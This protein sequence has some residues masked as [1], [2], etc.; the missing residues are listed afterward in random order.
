MELLE[1]KN[2][3][4]IDPGAP[5]PTI[6]ANDTELHITF[7]YPSPEENE[8]KERNPK[9]DLVSYSIRFINFY[10]MK[11]GGPNDE[12]LAGHPYYSIGLRAYS[13]YE[14]YESNWLSEL[15]RIEMSHP[16]Y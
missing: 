7:Y 16:Y 10:Q 9:M 4:E 13:F 12:S 2:L 5:S 15:K 8:L 1:I 14:L 3:L 11:F 6:I